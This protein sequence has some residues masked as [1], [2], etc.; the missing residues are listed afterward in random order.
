MV[1]EI[2]LFINDLSVG[3]PHQYTSRK[4]I[5]QILIDYIIH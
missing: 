4:E 3:N 2:F 5:S 1:E